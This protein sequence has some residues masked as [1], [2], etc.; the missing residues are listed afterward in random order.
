MMPHRVNHI[1]KKTGVIYVYE[2]QSYWTKKQTSNKQVC[3][4][5]T[6][7]AIKAGENPKN[8]LPRHKSANHIHGLF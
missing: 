5:K 8:L 1:N 2:A 6:D 7:C 3:I 4:G